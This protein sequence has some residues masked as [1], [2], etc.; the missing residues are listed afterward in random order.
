M[1]GSEL[2]RVINDFLDKSEDERDLL[3]KIVRFSISLPNI[4]QKR[5]DII[6]RRLDLTKQ[7]FISKVVEASLIDIEERLGLISEEKTDQ[8][9][10]ISRQYSDEYTI[11]LMEELGY[12]GKRIER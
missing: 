7:E 10:N 9:G 6:C 3:N 1:S 4:T 5:L 12:S 8:F 2:D 11:E